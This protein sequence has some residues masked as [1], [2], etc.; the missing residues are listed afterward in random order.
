MDTRLVKTLPFI[1]I[2]DAKARP[3][4]PQDTV[5]PLVTRVITACLLDT[6]FERQRARMSVRS[7]RHLSDE[8]A[9]ILKGLRWPSPVVCYCACTLGRRDGASNTPLSSTSQRRQ[10][11]SMLS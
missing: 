10:G 11:R 6:L 7:L 9:S 5:I 1:S 4:D 3:P 8:R 2:A